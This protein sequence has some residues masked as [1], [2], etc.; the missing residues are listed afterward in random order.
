M[1]ASDPPEFVVRLANGVD[2]PTTPLIVVAPAVFIVKSWPPS[3]V[4]VKLILPDPLL[5]KTVE[6]ARFTFLKLKEL[7]VEIVPF[8]V[9][10]EGAIAVKPPAYV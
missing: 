1:I 6:P 3:I 7:D 4:E 5:V 8:K 2:P 10:P 9:V